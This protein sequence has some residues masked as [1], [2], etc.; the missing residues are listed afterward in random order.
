MAAQKGNNFTL[1]IGNGATPEVFTTV[2][3]A[4]S[5]SFEVSNDVIDITT[6]DTSRF[7][8]IMDQGGMTSF[9]TAIQGIWKG[10]AGA[11]ALKAGVFNSQVKNCKLL[12]EDGTTISGPFHF[13][14]FSF[15]GEHHG[16]VQFSA[17]LNNAGTLSF[18]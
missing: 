14:N 15:T 12:F 1:Q 7:R 4:T 11:Q 6:K 3:G 9:S 17:T 18:T 2:A 8:E 5:N 13:T 16:A 10:D